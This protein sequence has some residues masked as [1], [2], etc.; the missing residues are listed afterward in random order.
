MSAPHQFGAE[1]YRH[2]LTAITAP[3]DA[4]LQRF[5]DRVTMAAALLRAGGGRKR[6]TM[7]DAQAA[8]K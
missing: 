6:P 2:V 7:Q 3:A 1:R 8:H 5:D 4:A